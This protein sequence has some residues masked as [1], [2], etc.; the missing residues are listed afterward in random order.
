MPSSVQEILGRIVYLLIAALSRRTFPQ[1]LHQAGCS[2]SMI[3]DE[4]FHT[5]IQSG[6]QTRTWDGPA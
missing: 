1:R 6:D 2:S 5:L 3:M 4:K